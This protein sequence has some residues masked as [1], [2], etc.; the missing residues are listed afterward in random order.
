M[1]H[2]QLSACLVND[3]QALNDPHTSEQVERNVYLGH[4]GV[5]EQTGYRVIQLIAP[6]K[7]KIWSLIFNVLVEKRGR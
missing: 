3:P 7:G 6:K 5:V 4:T 2:L 1:A